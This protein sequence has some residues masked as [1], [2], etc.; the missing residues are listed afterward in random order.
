MVART[1]RA[2]PTYL[3][4]ASNALHS[5]TKFAQ[6]WGHRDDLINSAKYTHAAILNAL[7]ALAQRKGL[8]F[9]D[10]ATLLDMLFVFQDFEIMFLED[11]HVDEVILLHVCKWPLLDIYGDSQPPGKTMLLDAIGMGEIIISEC[12]P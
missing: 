9:D 11:L 12:M 5:A 8:P 4:D 2:Y 10:E 1:D 7:K 6:F 3:A